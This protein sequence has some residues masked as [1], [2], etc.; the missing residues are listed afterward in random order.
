MT[1]S[2]SVVI[3][4]YNEAEH[5]GRLLSGIQQQTLRPDEVI[6]VDSGSTD[7]TVEIA[8]RF[9]THIVC[10]Q[11]EQFT[12]GRALNIGCQAASGDILVFASAHVYPIYSDWLEEMVRPFED[13]T[14]A[15]TYGRQQGDHRTRFSEHQVFA[16]WF[17]TDSV[18]HQSHP[19]C[20]NANAAVRRSVWQQLPYDE[21]LTGLE[22]MDWARR[23]MTAGYGLSYVAEAPVAHIHNERFAQIK[24]RY[25]REAIAHR[26]IFPEQTLTK[27]QAL[28]Y[29]L[30]N[31]ASDYWHSILRGK[32]FEAFADIPRF[33]IAQ[34]L[35]SLQGFEQ[36]GP[37]AATLLRHF[38]Y[39]NGLA[40]KAPI[41]LDEHRLSRE[42]NYESLKERNAA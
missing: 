15:L 40:T 16:K 24:N 23:M 37:V 9:D 12:F 13:E 18:P 26:Q 27:S 14:I 31:I 4:C 25:R 33:R 34:F 11:P 29:G 19:F 1:P 5:I 8:R 35:G 39:P 7:A 36:R 17:P 32:F 3:R 42:I 6:V 30:A 20:N 28:R 21:A 22:D 38:Y 2:V 41:S 10:I